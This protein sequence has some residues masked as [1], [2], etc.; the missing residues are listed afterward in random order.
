MRL[1][2]KI[3]STRYAPDN[4][5]NRPL[6]ARGLIS[7]RYVTPH[8]YIMIGAK[9]DADAL[10]EAQRSL[11]AGEVKWEQLQVWNGTTYISLSATD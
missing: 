1:T 3:R 9:D 2:Q 6:A 8:N 4:M 11:T 10:C 5:V 7:Y